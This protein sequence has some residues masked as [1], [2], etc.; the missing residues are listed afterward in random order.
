MDD[1]KIVF[2]SLSGVI[3][4]CRC[5]FFFLNIFYIHLFLFYFQELS[6]SGVYDFDIARGFS[7][8]RIGGID[9]RLPC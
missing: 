5:L 2:L 1:C 9:D 4:F 3:P 6:K 8:V 7:L